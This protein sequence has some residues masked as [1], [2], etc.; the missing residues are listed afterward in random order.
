MELKGI[1]ADHLTTK[2]DEGGGG[3]HIKQQRLQRGDGGCPIRK[4]R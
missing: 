3:I 2:F 4:Q 1:I